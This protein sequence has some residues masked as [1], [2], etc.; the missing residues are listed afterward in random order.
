MRSLLDAVGSGRFRRR[1]GVLLAAARHRC[2]QSPISKWGIRP[3]L[4]SP[5]SAHNPHMNTDRILTR[6]IVTALLSGGVAVTGLGMSAG[7]A[8]RCRTIWIGVGR[9][10]VSSGIWV[11]AIPGTEWLRARAMFPGAHNQSD[12]WEGPNPPPPA[13]PPPAGPPPPCIPFVNCL[14]GL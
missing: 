1:G 10:K 11:F 12:V 6:I 14:P 8:G 2:G 13:P 4:V 5:R 7:T 3:M 9:T